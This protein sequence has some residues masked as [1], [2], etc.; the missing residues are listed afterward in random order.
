MSATSGEARDKLRKLRATGRNRSHARQ[1]RNFRS[2][3]D[4]T[5]STIVLGA[6]DDGWNDGYEAGYQQALVSLA[7]ALADTIR[8]QRSGIMST[9][10]A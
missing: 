10:L 4:E 1:M 8:A 6:Y 7:G 5:E 3:G 2:G 9:G